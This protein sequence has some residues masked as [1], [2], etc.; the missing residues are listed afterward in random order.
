MCTT[1]FSYNYNV[2]YPIIIASN[3][4]EFYDRPTLDAN[5]WS[6][7]PNVIGGIDKKYSG[8]WL[9]ITKEG[10]IGILTN[11][12]NPKNHRTNLKS[13]G[14]LLKNFLI[15]NLSIDDFVQ[16]LIKNK[17]EY[18]GYN[19]V[20]NN[21]EIRKELIRIKGRD[22][23]IGRALLYATTQ[24]FLELF[25]LDTLKDLPTLDELT[26]IM[27]ESKDLRMHSDEN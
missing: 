9:G 1:F 10:K 23:G 6:E 14:I 18:N 12:R 5:F 7:Y 21:P 20:S 17:E 3:R 19:V 4:D 11:Y 16:I 26:E 27:D 22:E 8:T 13:R 2:N 24:A 25:G 15:D